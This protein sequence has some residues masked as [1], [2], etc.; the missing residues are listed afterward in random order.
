MRM[1]W[2]V[3]A[4]VASAGCSGKN[5]SSG[6]RTE[7]SG[8][9]SASAA[10]KPPPAPLPPPVAN[11]ADPGGATGKARWGVSF[12]G[13]GTDYARA[14]AVG[15]D[16]TI[17]VAGYFDG[18]CTFGKLG[19]RTA[20]PS[21]DP[22][23]PTSDVFVAGL[24]KNGA[25][26]WVATFGGPRDDVANGVAVGKDG[27]TVVV[28]NFLDNLDVAS[29]DGKTHLKAMAAG[30]DDLFAAAF[31][32]TGKPLWLWTAGGIN[33]DGADTVV[34]TADGGWLVG[35]S[36]IGEAKFGD[37]IYTSAGGHDAMLIKLAPTGEVQWLEQMGG[38]YN[39]SLNALA[40]DGRGNIYLLAEF[41]DSAAFGGAKLPNQGNA[42]ADLAVAKLDPKGKHIWSKSFGSKT[43]DA[44]GGIA[45]DPAGNV[46]VT[47]SFEGELFLDGQSYRALGQ[48][49]IIAAHFDTNGATQWVKTWG[50]DGTDIGAAI[51]ADAAGNTVLTGWFEGSVVFGDKVVSSHGNRDVV[52][53][54]LD[55]KGAIVWLDT[56]GDHDH[57]Q[58]RAIALDSDGN[59]VV[60]GVYRY[61]LD[62]VAPPLDS[63]RAA[64]DPLPK[65]DIFVL[66]LSR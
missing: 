21:D 27:T 30:S 28:G 36:F 46:T 47:G 42:G 37:K 65:T 53:I 6:T 4:L 49:D 14:V 13:L 29:Q 52:V 26:T 35:G 54:K 40:L 45:V 19:K 7:G 20:T 10:P 62:A 2:V 12:G 43:T 59:P 64:D 24:D 66:G 9:A 57:D 11:A 32:K 18:E 5:D 33:S 22:K 39:D 34:A 61:K 23:K 50:A 48:F 38:D 58:G 25:P 17:A 60:T 15:P 41:V 1:S 63:V 3:A 51:A 31:D 16:G 56:F 55:P 44:A 8:S